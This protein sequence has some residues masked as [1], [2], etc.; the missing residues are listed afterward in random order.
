MPVTA[1]FVREHAAVLARYID[2]LVESHGDIY[3]E[4]IAGWEELD[5]NLPDMARL[6]STTMDDLTYF[7]RQQKEME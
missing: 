3:Y 6:H 1:K 7:I 4:P 2:S 5:G